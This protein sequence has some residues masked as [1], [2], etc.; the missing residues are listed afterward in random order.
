V[1]Q[2]QGTA[3]CGLDRLELIRAEDVLIIASRT[4]EWGTNLLNGQFERL[5]TLA[6]Q[7]DNRAEVRSHAA[8][9]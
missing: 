5:A 7:F 1:R 8:I 3:E 4:F 2:D 9:L 6:A